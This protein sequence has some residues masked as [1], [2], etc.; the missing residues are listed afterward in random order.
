[1]LSPKM[2]RRCE[3]TVQRFAGDTVVR[4][5]RD[6]LPLPASLYGLIVERID[7]EP[8]CVVPN[9]SVTEAT[10]WALLYRVARRLTSAPRGVAY[11]RP[12]EPGNSILAILRKRRTRPQ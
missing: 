10:D 11:E 1:V 6:G 7:A 3:P 8:H 4:M 5:P 9:D 2:W 12:R